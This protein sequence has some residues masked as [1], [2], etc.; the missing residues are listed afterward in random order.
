MK[1]EL[2]VSIKFKYIMQY[3]LSERDRYCKVRK[4]NWCTY[5]SNNAATTKISNATNAA[6]TETANAT[7]ASTTKTS[8]TTKTTTTTKQNILSTSVNNAY[9]KN[10]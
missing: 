4:S 8:N 5:V 6:A 2:L 10:F 7:N 1:Q 3:K 9:K